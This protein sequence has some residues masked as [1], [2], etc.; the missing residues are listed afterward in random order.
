[1]ASSS[2]SVKFKPAVAWFFPLKTYISINFYPGFIEDLAVAAKA[3]KLT[4]KNV[5]H[6][7]IQKI[8]AYI[9]DPKISVR[10]DRFM[11]LFYMVIFE[12]ET[13]ENREKKK[14]T[15][16]TIIFETAHE[17]AIFIRSI[18]MYSNAIGAKTVFDLMYLKARMNHCLD[19]AICMEDDEQRLYK[20]HL[21]SFNHRITATNAARQPKIEEKKIDTGIAALGSSIPM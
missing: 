16:C 7:P 8:A 6:I 14:M 18:R 2:N 21:S 1:M 10:F 4:D 12:V 13:I 17:A 20:H 15:A 5:S 9:E 3:G 19:Y 11:M